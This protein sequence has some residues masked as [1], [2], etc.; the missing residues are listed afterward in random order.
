MADEEGYTYLA[1][2]ADLKWTGILSDAEIEERWKNSADF[3]NVGIGTL[4]KIFDHE[5]DLNKRLR[6]LRKSVLNNSRA[7]IQNNFGNSYTWTKAGYHEDGTQAFSEHFTR[8]YHEW[9]KEDEAVD[10]ENRKAGKYISVQHE[11][12]VKIAADLACKN[13]LKC[14]TACSF[15]MHQPVELFP[16]IPKP[17][18]KQVTNVVEVNGA[19]DNTRVV[20]GYWWKPDKKNKEYFVLD[21]AVLLNDTLHI[22]IEIQKSHANSKRKTEAF[23]KYSI[24]NVQIDASY[25][26]HLCAKAKRKGDI[27]DIVVHH[28]PKTVKEVWF[29][30][31][32]ETAHAPA[33]EQWEKDEKE[34]KIAEEQK[35]LEELEK[36]E[37]KRREEAEASRRLREEE[38]VLERKRE[39]YESSRLTTFTN[40]EKGK[41]L[42]GKLTRSKFNPIIFI[43]FSQVDSKY[44]KILAAT[45][46]ALNDLLNYVNNTVCYFVSWKVE[47]VIS[48]VKSAGSVTLG[49]NVPKFDVWLKQRG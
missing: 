6:E 4:V 37:R 39:E 20:L 28:H 29:C 30:E 44:I 8:F 7:T 43:L 45:Q 19:G 24:M 21:A 40:P 25:L 22:A 1:T 47:G 12:A 42:K 10:E 15:H 32:C 46:A 2:I 14:F 49:S 36:E 11:K 41:Y 35:R 26:I 38:L 31:T 17:Y 3:R 48:K 34:R 9:E 13:M 5:V 23:K 18:Q 33:I 27:V 16:W